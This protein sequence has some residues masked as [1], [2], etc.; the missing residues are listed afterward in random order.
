MT[1][2]DGKLV[3]VGEDDAGDELYLNAFRLDRLD[4]KSWTQLRTE[5]DARS[6]GDER[7][8]HGAGVVSSYDAS[9][10]RRKPGGPMVTTWHGGLVLDPRGKG[11]WARLPARPED[12]LVG[13]AQDWLFAA[14]GAWVVSDR[15]AYDTA[16]ASVRPIP[17]VPTGLERSQAVW[18]GDRVFV[19]G[20]MR[21]VDGGLGPVG[22]GWT[23]TP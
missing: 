11:T 3:Q 15:Y 5:G 12:Q 10:S 21:P 4:A 13:A 17:Q 7:L 9:V 16:N 8:S 23:L 22:D 19:W 14:A 2:V 6:W 18:A 1:A 20:G